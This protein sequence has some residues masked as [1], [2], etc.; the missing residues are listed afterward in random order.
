MGEVYL[1]R[2]DD[3]AFEKKVAVKLVRRG[4][5]TDFNLRRFRLERRALA[6]LEHPNI[7]RLIDGGATADGVPYFVME[8]VA[9]RTLFD[10]C[11]RRELDLT[12]RLELFRQIC[13]AVAHAHEKQIVHRDLKPGNI[14]VTDEGAVKLLDFGIAKIFDEELLGEPVMQTET[15]LRQMTPEYA[16][17]EQI[18]GEDITPATDVYSLGVILCELVTGERP[19]KFPSRAPHE[20]ARVICEEKIRLPR[21]KFPVPDV[22]ALNFIIFKTLEKKPR[23]RFSSVRALDS[24]VA[25][26]LKGL[27]LATE[28]TRLKIFESSSGNSGGASVSL[29]VAP[30][31]I[32]PAVGS[33]TTAGKI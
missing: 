31:Q 17:P 22:E 9:G 8:Y 23:A 14:L 29:A 3:G 13:A 4:I 32:L 16:S 27:P 1:A 6:A 19:Y 5:D 25:R 20:I 12:A 28:D 18:K 26:F 7:A 21:Y 11:D 30:F 24:A 2:R 33:K 15:L 10:Y